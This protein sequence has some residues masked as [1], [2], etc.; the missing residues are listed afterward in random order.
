VTFIATY[1]NGLVG[2][3]RAQVKASIEGL[4]DTTAPIG[5]FAD[6]GD[7]TVPSAMTAFASTGY[8]GTGS[9]VA[10]YV[11]DSTADASLAAAHPR[12][13]KADAL[14]RY[15]RLLPSPDG[16]IPVA[17]LGAAGTGN[18]QPA[19]QA[20]INYAVAIGAKGVRFLP[21]HESW[22]PAFPGGSPNAWLGCHIR[23]TG[24]VALIGAPGGTTFTLKNSSG[25]ARSKTDGIPT[26]WSGWLVYDTSGP[27]KSVIR[28]ITVEGGLTFSNVYANTENNIQDKGL[29][30]SDAYAPNIVTVDHRNVTM[31]NFGGEIWYM[32]GAYAATKVYVE[33]LTLAGSPQATWNPGS[34]AQVV[35]VNL[36]SSRAYQT[37]EVISGAGHT[38]IG[39]RFWD[40]G[41]GGCSFISTSS[42]NGSYAY[43]YPF[44][45][46]SVAPAWTTF[47]GTRFEA[48]SHGGQPG[49]SS[50][51]RGRI[52]TVDGSLA[53]N[54]TAGDLRDI[55]L[56]VES[57]ADRQSNFPAVDLAG[58][59]TTTTA[60]SGA[61]AG[62]Y[63]QKPHNVSIRV[64]C[65][66]TA[67][68]V[69][70]GRQH[71]C[72]IEI[73]GP[74]GLLDSASVRLAVTGTAKAS[75]QINGTP[76]S[77][78]A[79]PLI[80]VRDFVALQYLGGGSFLDFDNGAGA[81]LSSKA[82]DII[83]PGYQIEPA[84][85]GICR[86]TI[87]TTY[88]YVRGQRVRFIHNH[89]ST[90]RI[91]VF[92]KAASGLLL[93]RTVALARRGD[94]LELE[95]SDQANAWVDVGFSASPLTGSATYDAPSIAAGASTTTTVTV[96]GAELGDDASARLAISAGGL[97]MTQ[98]VSAADTVTVVLANLSG[99]AI[100]LAS[101]TLTAEVIKR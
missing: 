12:A 11:A 68:A 39:G 76:A 32:G 98:Y 75:W 57:W 28:D 16:L 69:A 59:A 17:A 77:G 22:Q 10:S 31:R 18:D 100:D 99:G 83:A 97:S 9:G 92:G 46:N 90:N 15:F 38:Y 35:A 66:R 14:G 5:L 96:T 70:N 56:E 33:N 88:G 72:G 20:A 86:V 80:N 51:T 61:P 62:T 43:S 79:L 2:S 65:C 93:S 3:E 30:I 64:N 37:A 73:N 82:L 81:L 1:F 34:L 84:A 36:D 54:W 47:E 89:N 25:A 48:G 63:I 101:T 85:A 78:F 44:R 45:D 8:A 67:L 87:N 27:T 74:N 55:D 49:F 21:A 19:I 13:C 24:D 29:C 60:V 26:W 4:I 58:P 42:F 23:V 94:W 91:I 71:S 7:I 6:L 53:V 52:C 41:A 95:W 40:W 50:W